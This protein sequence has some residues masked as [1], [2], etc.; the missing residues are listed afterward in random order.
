MDLGTCDSDETNDAISAVE[1]LIAMIARAG[2]QIPQGGVALDTTFGV[3]I[4]SVF[5]PGLTIKR[6]CECSGW[7]MCATAAE[8]VTA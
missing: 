3:V 5:V 8:V 6:L 7:R 1:F 4:F 2:K